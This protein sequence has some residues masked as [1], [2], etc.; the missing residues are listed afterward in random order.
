MKNNPQEQYYII[1]SDIRQFKVINDIFGPEAGD[2]ILRTIADSIRDADDHNRVYGRISGDSFAICMPACNFSEDS[3]FMRSGSTLRIKGIN[4]PIV[5]HMGI[6]EVDDLSLPVSS[7]CDRAMLAISSMK[8]NVQQ[9]IIYYDEH[10]RK[11]ILQEQEILK[12]LTPA[13]EEKQFT[14]YIQ[15]QFN[16][17][18]GE[19][20]GGETLVRWKHPKKGLLK[21]QVFTSMMEDKGL[22]SKLDRY[23]WRMACEFIKK[24]ENQGKKISLS[25]NISPKDFYYL[26]LYREFMGLVKE[27]DISPAGLKLEITESAVIMDVPKQVALIEKL[28]AEGFVVEMDDFGSGYSSLNTLKDIPVDILK[29]DMKFMEKSKNTKRS[30]DIV[31][32]VVAMADKLGMPVIAEGVETKEQADFLG[33]IGCD[34]IQGYYYAK[35]MSMEE[36]EQ[37]LNKYPYRDIVQKG[38]GND[39]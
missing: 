34:I 15:P 27:Y 13:F 38:I 21:P 36:F 9:Q 18:T 17:R 22:I 31:Q 30:A 35:P 10:M 16:H 20:A 29:L 28:Q 3:Y 19:I 12:D 23:V 39:I 8:N 1:C 5:N 7:M 25:V 26:D 37:L 2:R 6:Y 33:R 32:M 4:Y 24:L 14:I 11:E